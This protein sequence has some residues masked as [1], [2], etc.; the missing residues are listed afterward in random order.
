MV[1]LENVGFIIYYRYSDVFDRL[2]DEDVAALVRHSIRYSATKEDDEENRTEDD[3]GY[4]ARLVWE[5]FKHQI[6]EDRDREY[7]A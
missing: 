6:D 4:G 7:L 3:M 2:S 5:F 1:P